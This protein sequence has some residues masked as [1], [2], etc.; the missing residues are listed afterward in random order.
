V[1]SQ[2]I[3]EGAEEAWTEI[4]ISSSENKK[5]VIPSEKIT[6]GR[7][8]IYAK[9]IDSTGKDESEPSSYTVK[10]DNNKPTIAEPNI[11][12]EGKNGWYRENISI[13]INGDDIG[14]GINGYWYYLNGSETGIHQRDI[15]VPITINADGITTI[16]IKVADKAGNQSGEIE[17]TIKID[18][19]GPVF[20]T[21]LEKTKIGATSFTV[22]AHATDE[23]LG[24]DTSGMNKYKCTVIE[25]STGKQVK[26]VESNNGEFMVTGLKNLTRYDLRIVGIDNV[27][28]ESE[29]P[30]IDYVRTVGEL[31]APNIA[32]VPLVTNGKGNDIYYTCG[33][34][35]TVTDSVDP[36]VTSAEKFYYEIVDKDNEARVIKEKTEITNY[37]NFNTD[38]NFKI[39]AW[40]ED[41]EGVAGPKTEW[42]IFGIDTVKPGVPTINLDGTPSPITGS[43]WYKSNITATI[44]PGVDATSGAW[45][46]EYYVLGANP[47]TGE[48]DGKY[49]PIE[50]IGSTKSTSI[51]ITV[52]GK[53]QIYART[54]DKAGHKSDDATPKEAWKDTKEPGF[55][56]TQTAKANNS[57]T[58]SVTGTDTPKESGQEASG[59]PASQ[60]YSYYVKKSTD[61]S[62]PSTAKTTS[63]TTTKEITGLDQGT[64]YHIKVQATDNAG[65]L[66]TGEL[67]TSKTNTPPTLGGVT[68]NRTASGM[69][70]SVSA[71]DP[72]EEDTINY[73]V[74][75]GTSTSYGETKAGSG[76]TVNITLA[77]VTE[78]QNIYWKHL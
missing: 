64:S 70:L 48:I 57:I 65:N 38:G 4:D 36:N 14:S 8:T 16:K 46:V 39:R 47:I 54:V 23:V 1:N 50:I 32:I 17:R 27:G 37:T 74:Q 24:R 56:I 20:D 6:V 59:V 76:K 43:K 53:S 73:T 44:T 60:T 15:N 58:L 12:G 51:S 11:E 10:Y 31:K 68:V 69:S 75:Y 21:P 42:K 71:T 29:E 33:V 52:D 35:I 19:T 61:A 25:N 66:G 7:N 45:G 40:A 26:T 49:Q 9:I 30:C 78:K 22:V 55:T 5:A 72:D 18:K 77:G 34:K 62:Y 2:N 67:T 13:K 41:S 63:T 28:N 3:Q